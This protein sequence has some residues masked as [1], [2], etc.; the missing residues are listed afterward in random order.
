MKMYIFFAVTIVFLSSC[1][2]SK[3]AV[4]KELKTNNDEYV[5]KG[6][7][8]T[9][10]K[11]KM[12]F[13]EFATTEI[14]RSWTKGNSSR[15]GI[16]FGN[17]SQEDW[18][19]II[20]T[21]YINKKQTIRFQLADGSRLSEVFCASHFH[22]KDLQIG[23]RENS[24]LN[25]GLDIAGWGGTSSSFYYVQ[26]FTS[27]DED[28][29][30]QMIIDNQAAQSNPKKYVGFLAKNR[31][32]YYSITPVTKME[33]NGKE[34]NIL[35]GSIGYEFKNKEGNAVAAVSFLNKGMVFLGKIPTEERF[36]LANACT[37]LLLQDIIE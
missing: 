5:V 1:G 13:G 32:E 2:T 29:P 37:A 34:G 4:S 18:V 6:K 23:R 11:Q 8:G 7:D 22:S 10:I 14:K 25:I 17:P 21:E 36:L 19:N 24:I 33:V 28:Q 30:W 3:M 20:S 27:K 15:S 35:G 31:N 9:R 16:G 12:S 26:L